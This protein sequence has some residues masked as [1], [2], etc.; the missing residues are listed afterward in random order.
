MVVDE[1]KWTKLLAMRSFAPDRFQR[2]KGSEL[3]FEWAV[4][5]GMREPVVI[6][7][8]TGLGMVM[9]EPYMSVTD[10]ADICGKSLKFLVSFH[11]FLFKVEEN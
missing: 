6:L 7:D 3:T 2:I 1:F 4:K 11:S 10:V 5:T 8:P 9:P